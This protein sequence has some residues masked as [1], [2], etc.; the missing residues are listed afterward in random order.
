MALNNKVLQKLKAVVVVLVVV[1]CAKV[2]V[3]LNTK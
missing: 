1:H 2:H 3:S